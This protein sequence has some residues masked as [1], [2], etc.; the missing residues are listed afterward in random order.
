MATYDV[1]PYPAN[2]KWHYLIFRLM[3]ASVGPSVVVFDSQ[4]ENRQGYA[5]R[6][7]A[8]KAGIAQKEEIS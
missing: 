1:Y 4:A 2:R 7:E 3:D 5:T 8:L 6:D